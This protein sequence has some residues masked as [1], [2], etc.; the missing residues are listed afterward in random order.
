M[1]CFS[2]SE[3]MMFN[4]LVNNISTSVQMSVYWYEIPQTLLS[5]QLTLFVSLKV[6]KSHLKKK[7]N[8]ILLSNQGQSVNHS[9]LGGI[10][11]EIQAS[12]LIIVTKTKFNV[13]IYV[14]LWIS[15]WN[16]DLSN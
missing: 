14:Y 5:V 2:V 11:R 13:N 9:T 4:T 6:V 12:Y 15:I 3:T 10:L 7:N 16:D 8:K 1:T